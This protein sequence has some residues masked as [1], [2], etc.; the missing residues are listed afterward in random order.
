M[1]RSSSIEI[2][3][4]F[5]DS[6]TS[7]TGKTGEYEVTIERGSDEP[8]VTGF[9]AGARA[10]IWRRRATL[11]DK[12]AVSVMIAGAEGGVQTSFAY[13]QG[14][15]SVAGTVQQPQEGAEPEAGATDA[16]APAVPAV[17]LFAEP[18]TTI[19]AATDP[20]TPAEGAVAPAADAPA[21]D[22]WNF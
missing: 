22:V 5:D 7:L 10:K 21:Q 3:P 4:A 20:A 12:L 15:S 19:P 2:L 1:R 14:E 9:K 13:L 17:D 18:A 6:F 11:S 16:A 8:V